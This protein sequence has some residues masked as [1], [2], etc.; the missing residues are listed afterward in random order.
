[1][2]LWNKIA[3]AIDPSAPSAD[4]IFTLSDRGAQPTAEQSGL[5]R[6]KDAM[7]RAQRAL[8]HIENLA[9]A[10]P[11]GQKAVEE[12]GDLT[13]DLCTNL[14][15][16]KAIFNIP[17]NKD[18]VVRPFN[19]M[20]DPP[21][22]CTL[23]YIDGMTNGDR[24]N[25]AMHTMMQLPRMDRE[26]AEPIDPETHPVGGDRVPEWTVS[27]DRIERE[28]MVSAAVIRLHDI[29]S[30]IDALLVGDAVILI[31]GQKSALEIDVKLYPT[32]SVGEP[33]N[34]RTVWGP[35]DSFIESIRP[36]VVLV[37]RRMKDPRLVTEFFTIGR[38][39]RSWVGMLYLNGLTSPKLV[40]EVRRRLSSIDLDML[41]SV[42]VLQQSIEDRPNSVLPGT[43]VTERPDRTA[44]YLSEGNVVLM[45]DNTSQALIC[46][47]TFWS[48]MQTAEDYNV[49]PW[50]G[51]AVRWIRFLGLMLAL[52]GPALYIA[53]VNYHAD[54]LPT[55]LLL[56]IAKSR[57]KVPMPSL[58]ELLAMDLS[59]WLILE[60]TARIPS[61]L[62]STIGLIASLILGQAV[63]QA[64]IVGPVV[65]I[66]VA[67]TSLA[68]FVVPNYLTGIGLRLI[69][70]T[71]VAAAAVLGMYGLVG[72]FF[73]LL[74]YLVHMRTLGV[75]FLAPLAPLS[76]PLGELGD[77]PPDYQMETRPGYTR[78]IDEQRQP[79][80]VRAWDTDSFADREGKSLK[81]AERE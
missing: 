16:L 56:F 47:V 20:T 13:P 22:E 49:R 63:V 34:E 58:V 52:L 61:E 50:T 48:L 24:I 9:Q 43:M 17:S 65:L 75:P 44:A 23:L 25:L 14:D 30:C 38:V 74:L 8:T 29:K 15:R 19:L 51:T 21:V 72:F 26:R 31:D 11:E 81:G 68:A 27:L 5:S 12:A 62:G 80:V 77:M 1:M 40:A 42:G 45:L 67:L 6:L 18:V 78:T 3:N 70:I 35:R 76:R 54:M 55:E 60:A 57:E 71:L 36:N 41:T 53:I 73:G 69:R 79:P 59:F 10:L 37:R 66:V 64:K 39:S 33:A 2:A 28:L 4:A 46:P 7:L 32:R